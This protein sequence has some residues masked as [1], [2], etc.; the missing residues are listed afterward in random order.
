[1][2]IGNKYISDLGISDSLQIRDDVVY[3]SMYFER[4]FL[5]RD[6]IIYLPCLIHSYSYHL[7]ITDYPN[8]STF[9]LLHEKF[10]AQLRTLQ[11][12]KFSLS[13]YMDF[14]KIEI[15]EEFYSEYKK[16]C[17]YLY[18]KHK[19]VPDYEH[20]AKAFIVSEYIQGNYLIY[21]N[22]L[23]KV[24]F[25]PFTDYGRY[26]LNAH[27]FNILSLAKDKRHKLIAPKDFEF[28]EFDFNAFEIRVLLAILKINQPK[29]DLYEILHNMSDDFRQR[30][31]FKQFLISSI[32]SK[33]EHKTVLYK[34]LKARNFYQKYPI[35]NN[36]VT[37]IFGKTMNSDEYHRLSRIL[38]STAAYILYQQLYE[39]LVYLKKKNL[40]TKI[41]FC[42]H[43]SVCLSV[44]KDEKHLIKEMAEI[45]S[46]V[47]IVKLD[48]DSIFD[49]KIKNGKNYGEMKI[50]EA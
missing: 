20:L 49:I 44:H 41:S 16:V 43:D 18:D 7:Y 3:I 22:S 24:S 5:L 26:G 48:Y 27:S 15:I 34:F 17:L 38:Q 12:C 14:L 4:S 31:Q 39:L 11:V 33:N 13:N 6:D 42:I 1:M 10:K 29:G 36:T 8:Y 30:D 45:I 35:K 32:Y 50:Y 9:K 23:V 21:D 28:F 37:N 46:H 25:N 2:T 47:K 19:N 40:Q